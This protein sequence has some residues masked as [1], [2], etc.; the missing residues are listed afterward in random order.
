MKEFHPDIVL[1][2][3]WP[4]PKSWAGYD[5]DKLGRKEAVGR[6]EP[7]QKVFPSHWRNYT[8]I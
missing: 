5:L 2:G 3:A 8:A 1:I 4:D 7:R 6:E